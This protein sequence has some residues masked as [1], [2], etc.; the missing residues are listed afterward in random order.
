M[1]NTRNEEKKQSTFSMLS[2]KKGILKLVFFYFS[3]FSFREWMIRNESAKERERKKG[4]GKMK[5]KLKEYH[6]R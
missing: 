2:N 1:E 6:A 5:E 4:M 3:S